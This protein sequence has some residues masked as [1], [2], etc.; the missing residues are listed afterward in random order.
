MPLSAER[1]MAK[2]RSDVWDVLITLFENPIPEADSV[3]REIVTRVLG[4]PVDWSKPAIDFATNPYL[5]ELV[6]P[7]VSAIVWE[8]KERKNSHAR[9]VLDPIA[10]AGQERLLDFLGTSNEIICFHIL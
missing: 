7:G 9:S 8:T 10:F 2:H 1:A 4:K 6:R 5:K 3:S